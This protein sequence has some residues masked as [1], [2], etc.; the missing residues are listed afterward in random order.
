MTYFS[1]QDCRCPGCG[2]DIGYVPLIRPRLKTRG[3]GDCPKISDKPTLMLPVVTDSGLCSYC[4]MEEAYYQQQNRKI[5]AQPNTPPEKERQNELDPTTVAFLHRLESCTDATPR[6][7]GH[8]IVQRQKYDIWRQRQESRTVLWELP[9]LQPCGCA[10]SGLWSHRQDSLDCVRCSLARVGYRGEGLEDETW[11]Y[12]AQNGIVDP[13]QVLKVYLEPIILGLAQDAE[14]F[15]AWLGRNEQQ[16]RRFQLEETGKQQARRDE[17]TIAEKA[18]MK[19]L[20]Q[21]LENAEE[22]EQV[23]E[24]YRQHVRES[25][26]EH[27]C[28]FAEDPRPGVG[29]RRHS[30]AEAGKWESSVPQKLHTSVQPG[31]HTWP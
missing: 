12:A 14:E 6:R 21:E 8:M 20:A 16:L 24:E 3:F 25:F 27:F 2:D 11:I 17:V 23:R 10:Q 4:R 19:T 28:D 18:G 9:E 29:L 22:I 13:Q 1:Q 5:T 30:C 7:D 15:E 31:A 26:Q